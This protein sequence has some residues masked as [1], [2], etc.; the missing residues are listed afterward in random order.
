MLTL[1]VTD[2]TRRFGRRVV[3]DRLSFEIGPGEVVGV[4]GPNGSGK[5]T[6]LQLLAGLQRPS[7]GKVAYRRGR[8]LTPREARHW[9]GFVSPALALYDGLTAAE[10]LAFFAQWRGVTADV[11]GLLERVGLDPGRRE[12]LAAYSTGMRQRVKLAW[13]LM[14][15]PEA[16]L[17]DEPGSNLDAEGRALVASMVQEAARE[18][19]VLL[20]SNDPEELE[21]A[22]RTISLAR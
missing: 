16:L 14:H 3:I 12:P 1:N 10:N 15:E 6:L 9:C 2:L 18:G 20:A 13:A 21:L 8:E 11:A 22:H 17:L 19:W 5:S 4:T 7:R